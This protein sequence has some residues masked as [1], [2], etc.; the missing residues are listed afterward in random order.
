MYYISKIFLS[1]DDTKTSDISQE[2]ALYDQTYLST[3]KGAL[4]DYLN[5]DQIKLVLGYLEPSMFSFTAS[6]PMLPRSLM[7]TQ[8]ALMAHEMKS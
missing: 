6:Q 7:N 2:D 8:L 4:S 1:F 5:T 3:T